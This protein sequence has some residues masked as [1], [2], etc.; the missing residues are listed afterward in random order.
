MKTT[1]Y[2]RFRA[3]FHKELSIEKYKD[4][5]IKN[6]L[7]ADEAF[8]ANSV[9]LNKMGGTGRWAVADAQ[10]YMHSLVTGGAPTSFIFANNELCYNSAVKEDR[11]SDAEYFKKW[12][13]VKISDGH[14][15]T[16]MVL[17]AWNRNETLG[18]PTPKD[19]TIL[20]GF[21]ND[22]VKLPS[23]TYDVYGEDGDPTKG[24]GKKTVQISHGND[25]YST[26]PLS[27]KEHIKYHVKIKLE[28]YTNLTQEDCS[29]LC[30]NVN[31]GVQWTKELFRNT[32]TSDI[33]TLVRA[34]P[35]KYKKL[36]LEEGC[37]WFTSKQLSQRKA[38]AYFAE[39]FWMFNNDWTKQALTTTKLDDI[40]TV[41]RISE[42]VAK[43]MSSCVKYFFDNII[44]K[45]KDD[46]DAVK[47]LQFSNSIVIM[48]LFH[49]FLPFY[50][51]GYKILDKDLV[52]MFDDFMNTHSKLVLLA[53]N[54]PKTKTGVQ[55]L[56][57]YKK[58]ITGKQKSNAKICNE[59]ILKTFDIEK[60]LT[61]EGPRVVTDV[62]KEAIAHKQN[63]KTPEGKNIPSN[64]IHTKKFVKGHGKKAYKDTLTV[65]IKDTYVQAQIDNS[66]QGSNPIKL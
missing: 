63:M 59:L 39:L 24:I 7:V 30:R 40:Y 44:K 34:L 12:N 17:D 21:F 66:K 52:P 8:Q 43:Q 13:H 31:L 28:I 47:Y 22:K 60:Y 49:I 62:E 23:G 56:E 5:C 58:L 16:M 6:K 19:E 50:R 29:S 64:E 20:L 36:L 15:R 4:W 2:Y 38:D 25:T 14:M 1:Q 51:D 33:A 18:T 35:I 57:P 61:K 48:H 45:T 54:Y 26:L 3:S 46:F 11:I 53:K 37:K 55:V 42:K 10:N 65:D 9:F 32:Y 41:D 27:M